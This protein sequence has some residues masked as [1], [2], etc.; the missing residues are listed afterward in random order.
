MTNDSPCWWHSSVPLGRPD[1]PGDTR[2]N[3]RYA[4]RTGSTAL[5]T[6]VDAVPGTFLHAK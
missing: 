3:G 2:V 1:R 6:V 4:D 5:C